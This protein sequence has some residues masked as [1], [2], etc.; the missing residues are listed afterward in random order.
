MFVIHWKQGGG[1]R[2]LLVGVN[3]AG[4]NQWV[5]H[6]VWR[7][8]LGPKETGQEMEQGGPAGRSLQSP[9]RI[10]LGIFCLQM[11]FGKCNRL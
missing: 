10:T 11:V 5:S 2:I 1:N 6:T 4:Y 7:K 8:A 3:R 9:E